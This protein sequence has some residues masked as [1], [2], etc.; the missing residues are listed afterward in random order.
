[1]QR[2]RRFLSIATILIETAGV[3]VFA[4]AFCA[5]RANADSIA[6]DHLR[7]AYRGKTLIL[8][9]FY[10][11]NRLQYD[12]SG[13]LTGSANSGDWMSEGFVQV[14][15]IRSSHHHLIVEGER[16]L[17]I[18]YG[19]KEFAFLREKAED[20]DKRPV[21]IEAEIDP[22][23]AAQ[24][25]ADAVMAKIFLTA[26]DDLKTAVPDYWKPCLRIAAAGNSENF[27]MSS[28]LLAVPG[29]VS[30]AA[31]G[32]ASSEP[33]GPAAAESGDKTAE[34]GDKYAL[35]CATRTRGIRGVHPSAIYQPF[36]EFSD[37][38][39]QKKQ[40]GNVMVALVVNREGLAENVRI[41]RPLGY[42]LDEKALSYVRTWRF[43]PAEV[44]GEPV[45]MPI[46]VEVTFHLY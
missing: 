37:R 6:L 4:I 15:E 45:A 26:S 5:P 22:Q 29:A 10:F 1:M 30:G 25:Q 18:Q 43:K 46:S 17:V 13:T 2:M 8:R 42:G 35:N 32:L 16:Q 41:Q 44:D 9:G 39:R 11:G 38:A 7:D 20:V 23:N 14:K 27:R 19:G 31:P 40:Q 12:A 36:P 28:D 21:T 33:V 34:S 3:L 24:E